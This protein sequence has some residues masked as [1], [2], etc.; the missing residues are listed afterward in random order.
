V[1][2]EHIVQFSKHWEITHTIHTDNNPMNEITWK[3]M[4]DGCCSASS[5]CEIATKN[6]YKMQFLGLTTFF[7]ASLLWKPWASPKCNFLAWL[8]IQNKVSMVDRFK[9][10]GCKNSELCNL[11][12]QSQWSGTHLLFKCG[13]T[14]WVSCTLKNWLG[15]QDINPRDWWVDIIHKIEQSKKT[16]N[17]CVM[18]NLERCASFLKF[19]LYLDNACV[20]NQR[21]GEFFGVQSRQT[22]WVM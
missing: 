16:R 20:R 3:L 21:R 12:N 7:M 17:V 22:C 6:A 5:T 19:I 1:A 10:G 9:K 15:P 4:N 8:I 2:V 11:C 13:F 18:G 14:I